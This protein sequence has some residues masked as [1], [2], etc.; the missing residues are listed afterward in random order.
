MARH[1][2]KATVDSTKKTVLSTFCGW[3][4]WTQ[5]SWS[6]RSYVNI[7][8]GLYADLLHVREL[9]LFTFPPARRSSKKINFS[10]TWL[11]SYKCKASVY[12]F[13]WMSA[14]IAI[15]KAWNTVSIAGFSTLPVFEIQA[16]YLHNVCTFASCKENLY[17][18][19]QKSTLTLVILH[20]LSVVQNTNNF[21]PQFIQ[22][23]AF[24]W[25]CVC[26]AGVSCQI[27]CEMCAV[28]FTDFVSLQPNQTLRLLRTTAI[29]HFDYLTTMSPHS[30]LH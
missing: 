27:L 25:M 6:V 28:Q 14:E 20:H 8:L 24:Y 2:M 15:C 11:H 7:S 19:D 22:Q 16:P 12:L 17:K 9:Y 1:T 26:V 4:L 18:H 30:G 29:L 5:L 13:R 21:S 3:W 10:K 23:C